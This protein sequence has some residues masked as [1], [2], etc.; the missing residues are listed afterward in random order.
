M[1]IFDQ[2]KNVYISIKENLI[3]LPLKSEFAIAPQGAVG[4]VPLEANGTQSDDGATFS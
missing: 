2:T 1:C 4:C 3:N